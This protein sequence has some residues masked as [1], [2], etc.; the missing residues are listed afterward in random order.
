MLHHCQKCQLNQDLCFIISDL[1]HCVTWSRWSAARF[2]S[3][4]V[5]PER[6]FVE[7]LKNRRTKIQNYLW[8]SF[9]MFL[10]SKAIEL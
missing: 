10:R 7:M 8:S 3:I 1:S 5:K 6:L 9:A 4:F 2:V